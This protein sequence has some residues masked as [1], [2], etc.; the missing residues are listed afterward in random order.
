MS[1]ALVTGAGRGIGRAIALALGA[2]G[3]TVLC[4]SR[5]STCIST[6][7]AICNAGGKAAALQLDLAD[8]WAAD[9]VERWL[10]RTVVNHVPVYVVLAAAE[11]G[12][13]RSLL[14]TVMEE[15]TR[16]YRVNVLGNLAVAK[17][18]IPY[19][20][21]AGRV[22]ALT[23]G[24]AASAYPLF[25]AYAASKVALVRSIENLAEDMKSIK[26]FSAVALAPGAVDTAMLREVRSAGAEVR[27]ETAVD[28]AVHFV[29]MFVASPNASCLSGRFVHV[30]DDWA[31]VLQGTTMLSPEMWKL[32]RIEDHL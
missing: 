6:A 30:R 18:T 11:L 26:D 17:A 32:R 3:S 1:I 29:Q 9:D 15:W 28:E 31:D 21:L 10:H 8:Y 2:S 12:P 7:E 4:I 20:A 25:P 27:T 16:T 24:G 14:T 19:M 22:I 5:T 23:G 13:A